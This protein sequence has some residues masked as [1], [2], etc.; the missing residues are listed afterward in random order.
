MKS[1]IPLL[2]LVFIIVVFVCLAQFGLAIKL[3]LIPWRL[4][5]ECFWENLGASF[6]FLKD[7]IESYGIFF[8]I[9]KCSWILLKWFIKWGF[10]AFYYFIIDILPLLQFFILFVISVLQAI[11]FGIYEVSPFI[12]PL[13]FGEIFIYFIYCFFTYGILDA[14]I[15]SISILFAFI[16]TIQGPKAIFLIRRV[17]FQFRIGQNFGES[18]HF[19][20]FLDYVLFFMLVIFCILKVY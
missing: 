8:G 13:F 2:S 11:P 17:Y 9:L 4:L 6:F 15:K 3:G 20:Y 12:Y 19:V 14:L 7:N 5:W 18:I 10:K 1:F 16:L